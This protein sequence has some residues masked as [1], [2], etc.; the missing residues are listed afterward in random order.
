MTYGPIIILTYHGPMDVWTYYGLWTYNY[1]LWI[2][3]EPVDCCGGV[4][5]PV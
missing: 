2:N 3:M 1:D 4:L 5:R